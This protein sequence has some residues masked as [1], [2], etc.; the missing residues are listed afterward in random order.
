MK[1]KDDTEKLTLQMKTFCLNPSWNIFKNICENETI[2]KN[3][4]FSIWRAACIISYVD[5]W[6]ENKAFPDNS[7]YMIK[8]DEF[9]KYY[10]DEGKKIIVDIQNAPTIALLNHIWFMFYATGEIGFLQTAFE[11]GGTD[12]S[13]VLQDTAVDLYNRSKSL[14]MKRITTI[15]CN[16]APKFEYEDDNVI[17]LSK[18]LIKHA[19]EYKNLSKVVINAYTIFDR[20]EHKIS[21]LTAQHIES[22][23]ESDPENDEL[24]NG[25]E[26]IS[27]FLQKYPGFT[28]KDDSDEAI[29]ETNTKKEISDDLKEVEDVF[30]EVANE[31]FPPMSDDN[32]S[33]SSNGKK[34]IKKK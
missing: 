1:R 16:V 8:K 13:K 22:K 2:K 24:Q 5:S 26:D 4:S 19:D 31:L 25:L 30:N 15:N 34:I 7:K 10:T 12:C 18:H 27:S 6:A 20:F 11:V 21:D 29:P 33:N 23:G 14:F 28:D 3:K 32:S 9:V 17:N